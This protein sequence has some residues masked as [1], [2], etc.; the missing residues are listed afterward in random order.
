MVVA[1]TLFASMEAWAHWLDQYLQATTLLVSAG[2]VEGQVRLTP[3]VAVFGRIFAVLDADN[4]GAVSPAEQRTYGARVLRD[5]S[6]VIDGSRVP[7]QLRGVTIAA[8]TDMRG[9][10]GAIQVDFDAVVPR[11]NRVRQLTFDNTH[12]QAMAV[13]LVNALLP[14]DPGVSVT[15]QHRSADQSHFRLEYSVAGSAQVDS[16]AAETSLRSLWLGLVA[17]SAVA[18][19][20]V[21]TRARG[22]TPDSA[23]PRP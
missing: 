6:L 5:L 13:Y 21:A 8:L 10:R 20:I 15:L 3:G 1:A 23:A 4:D 11:G 19:L 2:R 18:A 9:G 16:S 17:L 14:E 22:R 7:M 12:Q